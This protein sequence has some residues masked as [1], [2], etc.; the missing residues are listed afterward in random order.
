MLLLV[1]VFLNFWIFLFRVLIEVFMW[2]LDRIFGVFGM[3]VFRIWMLNCFV[4][5]SMWF[6]SVVI[7]VWCGLVVLILFILLFF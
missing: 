2:M 3:G 5:R 4:F 6:I 7:R 1:W